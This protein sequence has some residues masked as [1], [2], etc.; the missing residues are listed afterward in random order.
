VR[1]FEAASRP[2]FVRLLRLVIRVYLVCGPRVHSAPHPLCPLVMIFST[3]AA[4]SVRFRFPKVS[5]GLVRD[6]SAGR[7]PRQTSRPSVN[8]AIRATAATRVEACSKVLG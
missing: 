8:S 4:N 1:A 3:Q 2:E 6:R 7:T 5:T